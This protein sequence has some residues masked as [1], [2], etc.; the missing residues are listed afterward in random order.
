ME[1]GKSIFLK[2]FHH[3]AV[4]NAHRGTSGGG[5]KWVALPLFQ[6]I[7]LVGAREVGLTGKLLVGVFRIEK[8]GSD[9]ASLIASELVSREFK[10]S[11]DRSC[12]K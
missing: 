9:W 6:W 7:W 8:L 12:G 1:S 2:A 11:L 5:G 3:G 10:E 4:L